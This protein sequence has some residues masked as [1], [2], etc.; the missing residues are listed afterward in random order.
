MFFI[1]MFF[2]YHPSRIIGKR[3]KV[4]RKNNITSMNNLHYITHSIATIRA[5][6]FLPLDLTAWEEATS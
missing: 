3:V 5:S 2:L 4:F 1:L 6:F